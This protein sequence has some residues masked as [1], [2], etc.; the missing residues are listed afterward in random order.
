[1]G[2]VFESLDHAFDGFVEHDANH[3]LHQAR[4]EF[5]VHIKIDGRRA[6]F[7]AFELPVVVEI[8]ERAVAIFHI[9]T[10]GPVLPRP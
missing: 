6:I 9:N 2:P 1:M 8:A 7:V 3:F 4:A 10:A 5:E